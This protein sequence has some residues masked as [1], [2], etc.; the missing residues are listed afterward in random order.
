[1][2]YLLGQQRIR[3]Y[4]SY[5]SQKN[6]FMLNAINNGSCWMPRQARCQAPCGAFYP[7]KSSDETANQYLEKYC[8]WVKERKN[9]IKNT[10]NK[11]IS[12]TVR[13]SSSEYQMNKASGVSTQ[14]ILF[15]RLQPK[16]GYERNDLDLLQ[17]NQSSDRAFPSRMKRYNKVN[18]P[19]HGNSTKTSLTRHR[20]GSLIDFNTPLIIRIV[21]KAMIASRI[22]IEKERIKTFTWREKI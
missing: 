8:G 21:I 5:N 4:G 2:P 11:R 13:V 22:F 19:S 10:D 1:M 20:P 3:A 18:V 7:D 9:T 15:N 14:S 12:D 17:W 6:S 16:P